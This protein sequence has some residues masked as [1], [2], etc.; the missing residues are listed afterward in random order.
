MYETLF[1]TVFGFLGCDVETSLCSVDRS[2]LQSV[3]SYAL[4]ASPSPPETRAFEKSK[5]KTSHLSAA[6]VTTAFRVPGRA[7]TPAPV[8]TARTFP[9]VPQGTAS[10]CVIKARSTGFQTGSGSA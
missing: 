4:P 9:R 8:G 7:E 2:A 3:F 6:D 5:S 10:A 1:V